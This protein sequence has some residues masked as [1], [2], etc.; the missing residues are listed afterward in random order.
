V[1]IARLEAARAA[2][3]AEGKGASSDA[4]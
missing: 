2:V 1:P 3:I 4:R